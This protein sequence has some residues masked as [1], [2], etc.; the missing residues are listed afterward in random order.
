MISES[1]ISQT[2]PLGWLGHFPTFAHRADQARHA[3]F[4][5]N[6][7]HHGRHRTAPRSFLW[8]KCSVLAWPAGHVVWLVGSSPGAVMRGRN[9]VFRLQNSGSPLRSYRPKK[10]GARFYPRSLLVVYCFGFCLSARREEHP[11]CRQAL[12][13]VLRMVPPV[14]LSVLSPAHSAAL[15]PACARK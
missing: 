4:E 10:S 15:R 3:N 8:H 13:S 7:R 2:R 12:T 14:A 9:F 6:A 5:W 11:P 1:A